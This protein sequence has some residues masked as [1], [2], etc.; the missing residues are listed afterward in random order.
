MGL[1][2]AAIVILAVGGWLWVRSRPLGQTAAVV[3]L[4]LRVR[5]ISS[6]APANGFDFPRREHSRPMF[7]PATARTF[8]NQPRPKVL[9]I[10]QLF[11][12]PYS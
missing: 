3:V 7:V 10:N 9:L 11:F 5:A 12:M 8:R 2:A 1:A 6:F 4:D